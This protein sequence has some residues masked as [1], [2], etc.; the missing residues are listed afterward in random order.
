MWKRSGWIGVYS[1]RSLKI[2]LISSLPPCRKP[3][4]CPALYADWSGGTQ[5]DLADHIGRL[6]LADHIGRL[7]LADHIGRL[8]LADHIGRLD[9]GQYLRDL[10]N[11]LPRFLAPQ[12]FSLTCEKVIEV[13]GL[14]ESCSALVAQQWFR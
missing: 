1:G 4:D 5:L 12:S 11:N 3:T 9:L 7:D 6:D 14:A 8:D 10:S 13:S 2:C